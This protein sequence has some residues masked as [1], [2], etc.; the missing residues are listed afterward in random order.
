MVGT[1]NH[2]HRVMVLY[3]SVKMWLALPVRHCEGEIHGNYPDQ[4]R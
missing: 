3:R 2:I 1:R 4:D